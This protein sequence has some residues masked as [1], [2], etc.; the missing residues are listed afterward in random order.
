MSDVPYIHAHMGPYDKISFV[1]KLGG[2][3]MQ[4]DRNQRSQPFPSHTGLA[5]NPDSKLG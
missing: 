3:D 1:F 5:D 2:N 4:S